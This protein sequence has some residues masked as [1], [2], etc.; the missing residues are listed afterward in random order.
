MD[1]ADVAI[2]ERIERLA[3]QA[4][5][6]AR[7]GQSVAEKVQHPV[8]AKLKAITEATSGYTGDALFHPS[9]S[10]KN[11]SWADLN[12]YSKDL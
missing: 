1:I 9:D 11:I 6:G 12:A 7:G 5:V 8:A 4:G 3:Y 2:L 10:T